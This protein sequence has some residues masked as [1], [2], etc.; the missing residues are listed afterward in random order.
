MKTKNKNETVTEFIDDK[1]QKPFVR[2]GEFSLHQV[3]KM[4]PEGPH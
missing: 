3:I 1:G 4:G 2:W